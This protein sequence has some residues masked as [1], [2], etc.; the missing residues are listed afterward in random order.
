MADKKH[1][2]L[3]SSPY[4][5]FV[6]ARMARHLDSDK[7]ESYKRHTREMWKAAQELLLQVKS[8]KPLDSEVAEW[9]AHI[10]GELLANRSSS[11]VEAL[12]HPGGISDTALISSA[13]ETAVIYRQALLD[14]TVLKKKLLVDKAPIKRLAKE[15]GVSRTTINSWIQKAPCDLWRR[16]AKAEHLDSEAREQ[17]LEASISRLLRKLKRD[18]SLYRKC[19]QSQPAIASRSKHQKE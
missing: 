14:E 11:E 2:L 1:E 12:K 7:S 4:E 5:A 3:H 9:L 8:N 13:K 18:S 15:Y 16:F 6:E 19:S 10:I 17:C